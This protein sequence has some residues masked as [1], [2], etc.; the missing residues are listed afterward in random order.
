[1][2]TRLL[3]CGL[4]LAISG[5]AAGAL[6]DHY[7]ESRSKYVNYGHR[8]NEGRSVYFSGG[9]LLLTLFPITA[10]IVLPCIVWMSPGIFLNQKL[11]Q[12]LYPTRWDQDY[13]SPAYAK[14]LESKSFKTSACGGTGN[15][16]I[17][18]F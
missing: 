1:M 10:V 15:P 16:Q 14:Y 4:G 7:F 9:E 8:N 17:T 18:F 11:D 3:Y 12:L 2:R 6:F 13:R 5:T